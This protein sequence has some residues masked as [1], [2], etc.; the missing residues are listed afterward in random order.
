MALKKAGRKPKEVTSATETVDTQVSSTLQKVLQELQQVAQN[1]QAA[2]QSAA[3]AAEQV[4]QAMQQ[5]SG[6]LSSDIKSNSTNKEID[7]T[8]TD[9]WWK[10]DSVFDASW[11][12]INKKDEVSRLNE[13]GRNSVDHDSNIKNAQEQYKQHSLKLSDMLNHVAYT[14]ASNNA[15]VNQLLNLRYASGHEGK[16]DASVMQ[17]LIQLLKTNQPNTK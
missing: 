9:E 11:M 1:G 17:A 6:S 14:V 7:D 15:L 3:Q 5:V 10:H 4:A 2:V 16:P 8:G 13:R 12:N